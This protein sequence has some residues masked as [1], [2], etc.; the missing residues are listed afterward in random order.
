MVRIRQNVPGTKPLIW[1]R[2]IVRE[3][4]PL[5]TER[6]DADRDEQDLATSL[7]ARRIEVRLG[8][9]DLT[10]FLGEFW[11]RRWIGLPTQRADTSGTASARI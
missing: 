1:H 2:L 11:S 9:M 6:V 7:P 10:D 5:T 3:I 4:I 8:K